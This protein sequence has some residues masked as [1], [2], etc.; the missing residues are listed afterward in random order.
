MSNKVWL[1]IVVIL[2]AL[3]S[4]LSWFITPVPGPPITKT[5]AGMATTVISVAFGLVTYLLNQ[6]KSLPD[7]PSATVREPYEVAIIWTIVTMSV[8]IVSV[9]S[10]IFGSLLYHPNLRRLGLALFV[11]DLVVIVVVPNIIS[12]Q[13]LS[14]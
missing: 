10:L 11:S 2:L 13:I 6:Y 14:G 8:G 5:V 9:I 4:V 1:V 3:F 12:W 7:N